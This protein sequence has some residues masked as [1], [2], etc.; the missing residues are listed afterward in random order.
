THRTER[1]QNQEQ[2][3]TRTVNWALRMQI[4]VKMPAGKTVT[5]EVESIYT[6]DNVKAKI[7]SEEG[8]SPEQ[9]RLIFAGK[10]L[11]DGCSLADYDIQKDSTL[12]LLLQLRGG[13]M[14]FEPSLRTLAEK[15][16][17]DKKICSTMEV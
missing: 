8:V 2:R 10:Q 11:D 6:V 15:Y 14:W 7:H 12:H 5:L 3:K 9:Q 1:V 4:F 16:N 13:N 17:S